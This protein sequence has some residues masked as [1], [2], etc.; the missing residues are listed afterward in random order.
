MK[1]PITGETAPWPWDVW[2][3]H[4]ATGLDAI[5]ERQLTNGC[6]ADGDH[7]G[8]G[9]WCRYEAWIEVVNE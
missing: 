8:N 1:R 5:Q 7:C 2:Q 6:D 9:C 4:D 3:P